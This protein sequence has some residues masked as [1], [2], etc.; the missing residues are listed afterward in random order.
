LNC[1]ASWSG[2]N[3][4]SFI[5]ASVQ[6]KT[7]ANFLD[8]GYLMNLQGLG[9]AATGHIFQANTAAAASHALRILIGSTPYYIMLTDTGA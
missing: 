6:G 2:T 4:V 8:Y 1:P 9:E 7:A 3:V 5:H